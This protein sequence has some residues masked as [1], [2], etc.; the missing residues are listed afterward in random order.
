MRPRP[1]RRLRY[2]LW[3]R[4]R[5]WREWWYADALMRAHVWREDRDDDYPRSCYG[6]QKPIVTDAMHLFHRAALYDLGGQPWEYTDPNP[7]PAFSLWR[8]WPAL[9]A[10]K[11]YGPPV[12]LR[13]FL[14]SFTMPRGGVTFRQEPS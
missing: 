12:S 10:A 5:P 14:P 6:G 13:D 9:P 1:L 7:M 3:R 11:P 4:T 8:I 2:R